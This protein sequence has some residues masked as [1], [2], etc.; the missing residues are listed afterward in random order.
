MHGDYDP[1]P[2]EGVEVPLKEVLKDFRFVLLERCGHEPWREQKAR[3][4]FFE[5]LRAEIIKKD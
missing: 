4:I 1:Q 3:A 2:V 5:L